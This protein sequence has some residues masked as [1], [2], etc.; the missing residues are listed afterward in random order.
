ME[1]NLTSLMKK[2][3]ETINSFDEEEVKNAIEK[4]YINTK[5]KHLIENTHY[6]LINEKGII[7]KSSYE[8]DLGLNLSEI[9]ILWE[10]LKTLEPGQIF[11][12]STTNEDETNFPW[13]YIYKKLSNDY[14]L[15]FGVD[16]HNEFN[17]IIFDPLL[18]FV[19]ESN[20]INNINIYSPYFESF[21]EKKNL[22]LKYIQYLQTIPEGKLHYINSGFYKYKAF[23]KLKSD[24][25]Y[26]Y[27]T[28]NL[29]YANSRNIFFSIITLIGFVPILILFLIRRFIIKETD[30]I[31][32][33]VKKTAETMKE[34]TKNDYNLNSSSIIDS[35]IQEISQ[36]KNEFLNMAKKIKISI[37]EQENT[38]S[39]LEELY[40]NNE[41]LIKKINRLIKLTVDSKKYENLEE[42]LKYL[43]DN[44]FDFIPEADY[45][46]L[47]IIRNGK[48]YFIDTKGHNL[49]ILKKIDLNDGL[50]IE[51]KEIKIIDDIIEFDKQ[52]IPKY[53]SDLFIE[54]SKPIKSTLIIPFNANGVIYGNMNLDIDKFSEKSFN[55]E[56][57]RFSKFFSD[58]ITSYIILSEY[59]NLDSKYK[60]SMIKSIINLVEI[61]DT[62]TKGHSNNVSKLALEFAQK[63]NLNKDRQFQIYWAALIHDMGKI[64]IPYE[65]LN[66]PTKLTSEEYEEIKKHT[67]YAYEVLKDI[68][69]MKDIAKYIRHHHERV[70]G[71]G[72]PDGLTGEEIPFESKLISICDAYDAMTSKR[73]YKRELSK[74]KAIE[75]LIK[76]KRKQF[77]EKLVDDFINLVLK[78]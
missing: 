45:G 71:N 73:S 40:E 3:L 5:Y 64:V 2:E 55:Q 72:Y 27:V 14:Y 20:T 16:F 74:E 35:E 23:Y 62:Y 63:L 50:F 29:D 57:I 41:L 12:Q 52:S 70:D 19:K 7:E 61:H 67:I 17:V 32:K 44:I 37:I 18:D 56:S 11:T 65:I 66:K 25:G 10:N 1:N 77:D 6:F 26:R 30:K 8:D 46:S 60:E 59:Q 76:N 43:F 28:L 21:L 39:E 49:D 36:I 4:I 42:F 75:E 78:E 13:L 54:A 22:E 33:P 68:D 48:R 58:I 53:S 15:E 9:N 38:N 31:I 47:S 69:N 51:E 34:Y 24:Y